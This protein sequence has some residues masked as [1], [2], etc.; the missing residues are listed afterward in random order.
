MTNGEKA[1][2]IPLTFV[3]SKAAQTNCKRERSLR[4]SIVDLAQSLSA[5]PAPPVINVAFFTG[6]AV[7]LWSLLQGVCTARQGTGVPHL[8][9]KIARHN[10]SILTL[11]FRSDI[12][13][14]SK[15]VLKTNGQ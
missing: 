6:L 5:L 1:S 12:S 8:H 7:Y 11:L 14:N 3:S 9:L 4:K 10:L 15:Q 13:A 2:W